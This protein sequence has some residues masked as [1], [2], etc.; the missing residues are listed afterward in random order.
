MTFTV[1]FF[2][3][4]EASTSLIV[5]VPLGLVASRMVPFWTVRTVMPSL[6][7]MPSRAVSALL[8][9]S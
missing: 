4:V 6:S 8:A 1:T 5:T 7:T 3:A 9:L 2:D